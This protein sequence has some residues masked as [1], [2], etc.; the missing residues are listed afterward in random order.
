MNLRQFNQRFL[1]P[2]SQLFMVGGIVFLC[3][4]WVP[5]LHEW[6]VLIMLLGIIGFNVAVHIPAPEPVDRPEASEGPAHG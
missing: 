2:G 4:P 5:L 3:Q 6:S 1:E